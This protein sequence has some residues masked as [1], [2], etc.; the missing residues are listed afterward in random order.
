VTF[1]RSL[2]DEE[3]DQFFMIMELAELGPVMSYDKE[4]RLF[5]SSLTG[6][7]VPEEVAKG[8]LL[9]IAAGLHYIHEHHVA[10]RDLKPDNVLR[11]ADGRYY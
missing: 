4:T 5:A 6:G 9:D 7:A 10:H 11:A 2:D 8:Y 1:Y 3:E